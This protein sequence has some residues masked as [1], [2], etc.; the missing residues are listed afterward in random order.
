MDVR[1]T[2]HLALWLTYSIHEAQGSDIICQHA[3]KGGFPA[4]KITEI[5]AIIGPATAKDA[6]AR[7]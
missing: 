1:I 6:T 5:T 4:N 2:S 3:L 7:N